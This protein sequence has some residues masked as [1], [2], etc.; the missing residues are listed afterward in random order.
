M[1]AGS[2][3]SNSKIMPNKLWN[4]L[5]TIH[6]NQSSKRQQKVV[7]DLQFT[8]KK[9]QKK[10][11]FGSLKILIF[12]NKKNLKDSQKFLQHRNNRPKSIIIIRVARQMRI[13]IRVSIN[14]QW[15]RR[16]LTNWSRTTTT[17]DLQKLSKI[18]SQIRRRRLEMKNF[19]CQG[20]ALS[21]R[22]RF[23][24]ALRIW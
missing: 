23:L 14:S 4:F 9:T 1:E 7:Q 2:M 21:L 12:L 6:K 3:N 8:T 22:P 17:T 5:T 16:C 10:K 18:F 11:Y 24:P 19:L 13:W 15:R 20:P